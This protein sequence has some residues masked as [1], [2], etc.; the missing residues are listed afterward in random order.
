MAFSS[1]Q[2][3]PLAVAVLA[4]MVA[5]ASAS[6]DI[7]IDAYRTDILPEQERGTGSATFI[8]GYR[9]AMLTAGAI[10]LILSDRIGWRST[11]LI[12]AGLLIIGMMGTLIG[13]EPDGKII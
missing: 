2:Y 10:A 11:Y 7:V 4:L 1:P 8:V 3:A 13:P 9:V 6:Q 12:M 5:F